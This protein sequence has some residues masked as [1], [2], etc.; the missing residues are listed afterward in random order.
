MYNRMAGNFKKYYDKTLIS[1]ETCYTNLHKEVLQRV[2][3]NSC[4]ADNYYRGDPNR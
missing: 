3:L 2:F 1:A 4:F